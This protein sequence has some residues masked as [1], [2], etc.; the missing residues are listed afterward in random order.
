MINCN[1]CKLIDQCHSK[2][3][4]VRKQLQNHDDTWCESYQSI[5]T[6]S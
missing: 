1:I 4:E 6:M 2:D 3:P 5:I